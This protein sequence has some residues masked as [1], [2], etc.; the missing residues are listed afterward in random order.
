MRWRREVVLTGMQQ[1]E[2][3]VRGREVVRM[4]RREVG[5]PFQAA[6]A[7]LEEPG[8]AGGS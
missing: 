5:L 4:W 6:L 3:G 8:P 2:F 7:H 1:Q